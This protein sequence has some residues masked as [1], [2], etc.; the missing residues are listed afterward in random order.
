[1]NRRSFISLL[2]WCLP[3]AFTG[4]PALADDHAPPTAPVKKMAADGERG[5]IIETIWGSVDLDQYIL[6]ENLAR[7]F[8]CSIE[9]IERLAIGRIV[10]RHRRNPDYFHQRLSTVNYIRYLRRKAA[11]Y[12]H[13]A[14]ERR[15]E[16]IIFHMEVSK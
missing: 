4:L 11:Y 6:E 14:R 15:D 16:D 10:V 7:L 1:M 9:Y 3:I 12:D 2:S 13:V 8:G 5:N